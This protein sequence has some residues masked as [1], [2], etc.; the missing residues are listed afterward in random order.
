MSKR[1]VRELR[2][3]YENIFQDAKY[4]YPTLVDELDKDLARLLKL[5]DCRGICVF[6]V[7]LPAAG[8]HFD[9]CLSTGQY[10]FAGLPLTG[11]RSANVRLPKF[12]GCL[13]LLVF[14]KDG[15][16]KEDCDVGAIRFIRQLY[17][18][19]KKATLDC[20]AQS[21]LDEVQEFCDV[22][23]L[24]PEPHRFWSEEAPTDEECAASHPGF[25]E[26]AWYLSK[27]G[28]DERSSMSDLLAYIDLTA[29]YVNAALG[30]YQ[31]DDWRFRHGPGA[32][33]ERTG[34]VNKYRFVNW[35]ERLESVY[36][37]ADYGFH[38]HSAWVD[39][40]Q[41]EQGSHP[42]G[43]APRAWEIGSSDPA[44]RLI[45]VPKTFLKPRL[46]AAEPTEHQWCQQNIWHYFCERVKHSWL[47]NF[48]RFRDQTRNQELCLLGSRTTLLATVDLSAASDRV[49]C[50]AVGNL[51]RANIGLLQALRASRTRYLE[52]SINSDVDERLRLRKFSTMGSA[53]TFPVESLMFM[54]VAIAAVLFTRRVQVTVENIASLSGEVTV[55]GDD[56]IVPIDCR[57]A[58]QRALEILDF[59][60]NSAKTFWIG[61]F[62]ESCGVDAYHGVDVTPAY[63]RS[64][65]EATPD[66]IASK[67]EVCNNF[68]EK[69]LL[70]TSSFLASTIRNGEI[71]TVAVDSGVFGFKSRTGPRLD[72]LKSR[73]NRDLQR[74]E[75]RVVRLSAKTTRSGI[76]DNS[77]L[78]QFFTEAPEPHEPWASGIG[79]R[80]RISLKRGWVPTSDLYSQQR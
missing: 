62:R 35:S 80:P 31:P 37:L 40:V 10:E 22:D 34:V 44:S 51:F 45:A 5:V 6:A 76:N 1:H 68:Y 64:P 41:S 49:S 57:L 29:G 79:Q 39:W 7:Y 8:K 19:A 53:C 25:R 36:P 14:N 48:I 54:T 72:S 17:M 2:E 78:L 52:Q 33:S 65:T 21:V 66:S 9:R 69:W 12:L 28:E 20:S 55:F 67:V 61:R 24:L 46:I 11:A 56:I 18:A 26:E 60:I 42:S 73:W 43:W 50:H 27:L 74:T 38:N 23:L 70:R 58:F 15:F 63:W 3:V 4:A 16:L 32:V 75:V 59:K 13:Y 30:H 71:P 47:A 77:A